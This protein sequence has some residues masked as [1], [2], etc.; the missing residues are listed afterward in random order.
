MEAN[1]ENPGGPSGSVQIGDDGS[2]AAIVPSRRAL[3]WQLTDSGG[4]AVV[5]ERYW[6]SF[7]PGEVRVC[8]SCHGLTDVDQLGQT[9]PTNVPEALTQLLTQWRTNPPPSNPS[10]DPLDPANPS[11]EVIIN[12]SAAQQYLPWNGFL[13]M[14]NILEIVNTGSTAQNVQ[15]TMFD[16][17]GTGTYTTSIRLTAGEQRDII[18]NSLSG[19]RSDAYGLVTLK[20]SGNKIDGR[21]TYYH[22]RAQSAERFDLAY[23]IPFQSPLMAQSAVTFNTYQPSTNP[24]E[25]NFQVTNWLSVANLDPQN[26]RSFTIYTYS[27]EGTLLKTSR[28]TIP[29]FARLDLDGGHVSPGANQ[30]GLHRIVPQTS[31]KPYLAQLVR[32]GGNAAAGATPE[33]YSFAFPMF[34]RSGG[35]KTEFVPISSGA[36]A[37]NWLEVSNYS[38]EAVSATVT[39]FDE[40][41]NSLG[42]PVRFELSPYS[43]FHLNAGSQLQPGHSGSARLVAS[44]ANALA[45]QSI[46]YFPANNSGSIAAMYGTTSAVPNAATISGS[47]NLF[48]GMNNWLK[49]LNTSNVT[50]QLAVTVKS[51]AGNTTK[52]FTIPARGALDL[53]LHDNTLFGTVA[54]SY[55]LV[56]VSGAPVLGQVLRLQST[57]TSLEFIFPTAMH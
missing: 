51:A 42:S 5:R 41:G 22:Q 34:A 43:Q 13:G 1:P 32:Y 7:K 46:Y 57:P 36:G 24:A 47:Y 11:N 12:R 10:G 20:Y 53:P 37:T 23:A 26:S 44:K 16:N 49:L 45:A 52:N 50:K 3:T 6:L 2:A 33:S 25:Q 48:L 18:L 9:Q 21:L 4:D 19:F 28:V 35:A 31:G 29:A 27:Q 15:V 54:N 17:S 8:A 38:S 40:V 30:V 55:G 14:T 56:T 39:L